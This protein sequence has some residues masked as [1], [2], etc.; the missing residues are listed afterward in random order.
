MK[1]RALK[2]GLFSAAVSFSSVANSSSLVTENQQNTRLPN[3]IHT[4]SLQ[5]K[6][7][8]TTY[9]MSRL[10]VLDTNI[11]SE[12]DIA[13]TTA[14]GLVDGS[15][16]TLP[17]CTVRDFTGHIYKIHA[18]KVADNYAPGTPS[19]WAVLKFEKVRKSSLI[20]YALASPLETRVFDELAETNLPVNFSTA[21]G[22]PGSGQDCFML[23][24]RNAGFD[25]ARYEGLI[26][27]NC[28]AVSGQ[29]GAPVSISRGKHSVIMGFHVGHAFLLESPHNDGPVRH[30][31]MRAFDDNLRKNVNA[32]IM[33]FKATESRQ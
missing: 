13:I 8:D 4:L 32:I 31:Y 28:H 2:I 20:R 3:A 15:G 33:D 1:L 16:G 11:H 6:T 23:P 24:R 9:R 7:S 14:H 25:P 12:Y 26:P 27:H 17:D 30:G 22:L 19:D 21:R 29:S 5:C 10:A 18:V